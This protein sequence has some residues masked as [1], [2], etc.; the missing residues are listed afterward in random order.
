MRIGITQHLI[1]EQ[2]DIAG[3]NKGCRAHGSMVTHCPPVRADTGA[4]KI[5]R[6]RRF[7]GE[8]RPACNQPYNEITTAASAWRYAVMISFAATE[9]ARDLQW[10]TDSVATS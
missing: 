6:Q 2:V 8:V 10:S 7:D 5:G 1:R 3:G 4:Q 9:T